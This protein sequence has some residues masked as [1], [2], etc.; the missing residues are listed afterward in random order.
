MFFTNLKYTRVLVKALMSSTSLYTNMALKESKHK[1]L[2]KQPYYVLSID[3]RE[4]NGYGFYEQSDIEIK[5]VPLEDRADLQEEFLHKPDEDYEYD[6]EDSGLLDKFLA[7]LHQVYTGETSDKTAR[8][9]T[10]MFLFSN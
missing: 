5:A 4:S 8:S 9:F 2:N 7:Y 3:E 10:V 6:Y 1:Q